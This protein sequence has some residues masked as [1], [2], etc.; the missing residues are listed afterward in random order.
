[1]HSLSSLTATN[2]EVNKVFEIQPEPLQLYSD[3][4]DKVVNIPLPLSHI[5]LAP[6]CC[7]LISA[8]KRQGMVNNL[9]EICDE[10]SNS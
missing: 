5:G 3:V 9:T 2:V 4:Y 10:F 7:R 1:M 6:V 8:K